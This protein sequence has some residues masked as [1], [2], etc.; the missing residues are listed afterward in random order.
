VLAIVVALIVSDG[1]ARRLTNFDSASAASERALFLSHLP[2]HA[3]NLTDDDDPAE[4]VHRAYGAGY[5]LHPFFGY[6]FRHDTSGANNRGFFASGRTYPYVKAPDEF[7]IGIFGG[8]VAMQVASA[9]GPLVERL[10]P[11]LLEKGYDRIVVLPFS[12][13][14]WREPQTF[15]ALVAYLPT[16]DMAVNLD[17]FNEVVQLTDDVLMAYPAS[18]PWS[19]VYGTLADEAS[20]PD[21]VIRRAKLVLANRIAASLTTAADAPVLRSSA[22]AHLAWRSAAS[23]HSRITARLRRDRHHTL[24]KTYRGLDPLPAGGVGAKRDAYLAELGQTWRLSDV[25]CRSS[26]RPF[27]QFLQP[28]QYVRGAKPLSE[29]E[30]TAFTAK[31]GW[32][33]VVTP[34]YE[35]LE[36]TTSRLRAAGIES[37]SLA[38]V[39]ADVPDTLYA[40]ACC[41]LNERGV[42]LLAAAMGDRIAASRS[43][44]AIPRRPSQAASFANAA[45]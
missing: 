16:I 10:R 40:D 18:Y 36:I 42:A 28:N 11:A 23:A 26:G 29:E 45:R 4:P 20:S 6:T 8:S 32:F 2:G 43:F 22:L 5:E 27:F 34:A 7:V 17:G 3:R 33:D 24:D 14:G 25:V 13:G 37:H 41:H 1:I 21:E 38:R 30:Q 35:R 12:V 31:E 19:E 44:A 9:P 39:F 15:A